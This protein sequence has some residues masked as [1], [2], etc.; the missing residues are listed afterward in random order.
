M[1]QAF[2][3]AVRSLL[4]VVLFDGFSGCNGSGGY[5]NS[6]TGTGTDTGSGGDTDTGTGWDT[7]WTPEGAAGSGPG[8]AR[9]RLA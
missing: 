6:D 2:S 7:G 8:E 5:D 1:N 3:L 9:V 4:F